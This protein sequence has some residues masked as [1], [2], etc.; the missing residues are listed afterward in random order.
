M[1]IISGGSIKT[2][3]GKMV[4]VIIITAIIRTF[5]CLNCWLL[6]FCSVNP[7]LRISWFEVIG[8]SSIASFKIV[9]Q[10]CR[11]T[12]RMEVLETLFCNLEK[13]ILTDRL[14]EHGND[15]HMSNI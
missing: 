1:I 4:M 10:V 9:W 12:L 5:L 14:M 8:L 2:V 11:W 3:I 6:N 15:F 13:T 7:W